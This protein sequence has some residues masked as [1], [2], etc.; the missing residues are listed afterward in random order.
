MI[1]NNPSICSRIFI[2]YPFGMT[3]PG[4]VETA[5]FEN[6]NLYN[7]KELMDE[8]NLNVYD[9]GARN[10]DPQLGRWLQVDPADEFNSPY[11]YVG[12][13][14]TI[15]V[16][17]DG[18]AAHLAFRELSGFLGNFGNHSF[19]VLIPDKPEEFK[20]YNLVKLR[21]GKSSM[22]YGLVIGAYKIKDK[23]VWEINNQSGVTAWNSK[24]IIKDYLVESNERENDTV[25][26]NNLLESA[27]KYKNDRDYEAFSYEKQVE[28]ENEANCHNFS[29]GVLKGAVSTNE[30]FEFIKPDK[31]N[32]GL[33]IPLPEQINEEKK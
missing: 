10:Y 1:N 21:S 26:L 31:L 17:P 2:Y 4:S 27:K 33:G 30:F 25:F 15:A 19:I 11:V 9:Y 16:D 3:I 32:P 29:T 14:P 23:L 24:S 5:A 20:D 6:K 22:E 12:N 13:M 8:H 7:S 28:E 18:R